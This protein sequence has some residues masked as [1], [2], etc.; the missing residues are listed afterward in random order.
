MID[1]I[2]ADDNIEFLDAIKYNLSQ[3]KQI[4]I[5][6]TAQN[7]QEAIEKCIKYNPNVILLDIQMP[8]IDGVQATKKIKQYNEN[9][10]VIILTTFDEDESISKAFLNGADNYLVKDIDTK[11][12]ISTINYVNDGMTLMQEKIQNKLKQIV[13]NQKT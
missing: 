6:S 1:L 4:N 12:I 9:I 13:K 5:V 11:T 2:I 8:I 7:G 3:E 10:K